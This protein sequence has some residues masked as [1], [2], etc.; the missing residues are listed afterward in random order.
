MKRRLQA[1][2]IDLVIAVDIS[3]TM[4]DELAINMDT[5]L[6]IAR[7]LPTVTTLRIGVVAFRED[8]KAFPLTQIHTVRVDGGQSLR[9]LERYLGTLKA[10]DGRADV[11]RAL[12]AATTML[13][14]ADDGVRR[15]CVA[16]LGDT[17]PFETRGAEPH[18]IDPGEPEKAEELIRYVQSWAAGDRRRVVACYS[19][20]SSA[21]TTQDRDARQKHAAS[22]RFYSSLAG[23]SG[24][25]FTE[26]PSRLLA[27]LLETATKGGTP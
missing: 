19:E 18:R 6:C 8:L 7:S 11:D 4:A 17:G 27:D 24:G 12:R 13:S 10:E 1:E 25:T 20:D 15:Q 5:L 23:R 2:S 22:R 21:L 26:N 3:Q 16:I 14:A 9:A